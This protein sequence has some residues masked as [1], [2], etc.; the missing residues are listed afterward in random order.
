MPRFK[1]RGFTLVELLVV[2]AIIGILIA[3]LLPAVQAAR[4]A[5]RRTQCTN[6]LKQMG[7]GLHNYHS[8]LRCFPIGNVYGTYWSFQMLLLPVLE[9]GPLYDQAD[10][11]AATCFMYN[12][13]LPDMKGV[14]A[15]PLAVTRCP[16]DPREGEIFYDPVYYGFDYGYYALGNYFGVM[17]TQRAPY[18][19]DGLLFSDSTTAIRDVLDGTS[20]T[21]IVGERGV[22]D[23]LR[24]GWWACGAGYDQTGDCD[25]LMTT[26]LGL[27]PGDES[28]A[29]GCHFWSYHPGGAN[30]LFADGSTQFLSYTIDYQ[31]FQGLS[32]RAGGE[33]VS[34]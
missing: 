34:F 28:D 7:L 30:F 21:L 29:H 19:N 20:N 27:T 13:N 12:A 17:G 24:L 9:Q 26:E 4:E 23:H 11:G 22:I 1:R 25:N 33:V 32:T 10:F 15:V 18:S 5:A 6:N 3:L 2:I 8:S 14:P 16:S 31:V